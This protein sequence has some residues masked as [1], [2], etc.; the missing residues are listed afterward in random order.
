VVEKS[1]LDEKFDD[2]VAAGKL[3]VMGKTEKE[4]QKMTLNI[5]NILPSQTVKVTFISI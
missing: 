3:V 5:G 1:S 2:A 4:Q